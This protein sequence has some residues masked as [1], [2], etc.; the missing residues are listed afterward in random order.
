MTTLILDADAIP[1]SSH[2]QVFTASR[3]DLSLPQP[4][5]RFFRHG[6][7]SWTLSTWLDPTDPPLP[8]RAPEFRAKDEDPAYAVHRNHVSTW[9]GAVELD[10]D[11]ILLIGALDLSGRV[12]L[13]GQYLKGF[14]EDEHEG[15]WLIARGQEDGVFAAYVSFLVAKFGKARFEKPPRVWCSWYSLYKWINEANLTKALHDLED[16]PFDV[17]Q[18]DDGWQDVSGNWEAG[19]NFPSGMAAFA[20]KVKATGRTAGIWL[21]PFIVTPNLKIF[22]EHPEWILRDEQGDMVS[23]GLNWTGNTYSL[24]ITHPEVLEWLDGLIRKVVGWGFDY[25]KLDFLYAGAAVGKHYKDIPREEA[26]RHAMQVMRNAAGD[27]YI[28]ACGAPIIPS[29]GLCDGIRVGPDVAP[30]WL[31]RALSVWL[32]NP[33]ETSTQNAIRTS[34]HRLWLRPLVNID[35]DV[36]YFRSKFNALKPHENQLLQDLGTITGFKA[37]SDLPGWWKDSE[38]EKVRDFLTTSST[39]QKKKRYEFEIDGRKVDFSPAVPIQTSY[40]GIPVWLARYTG[41]LKIGWYQVRPAILESIFN[42]WIPR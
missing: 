42:R 4:P 36:L 13:D 16:L 2:H 40:L 41:M 27:A 29:L 7:Q 1:E 11:D 22:R 24:D 28:L 5:K 8:I 3:I 25:L 35:P 9:V 38:K 15:E 39:V 37:T 19:K 30:Y 31:N 6:W 18:I 23:A 20:D 34:I 32:N 26:Y 12:E 17:F 33:N 14:Y 21:S 10:E